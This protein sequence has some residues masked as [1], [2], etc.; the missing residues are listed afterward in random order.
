MRRRICVTY[1]ILRGYVDA[2]RKLNRKN[3]AHGACAGRPGGFP[4]WLN[5][6]TRV[7]TARTRRHTAS[8]RRSKPRKTSGGARGRQGWARV[9]RRSTLGVG[10]RSAQKSVTTPEQPP[11]RPAEPLKERW[12]TAGVTWGPPVASGGT[13]VTLPVYLLGGRP[14]CTGRHAQRRRRPRSAER[15]EPPAPARLLPLPTAG[16]VRSTP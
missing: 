6:Q 12:S 4:G 2:T 15:K 16:S 11:P 10:G 5:G 3:G 7:N 8:G 13:A 9:G 14:P 1:Y